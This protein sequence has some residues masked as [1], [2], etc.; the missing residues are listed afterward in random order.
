MLDV[1]KGSLQESD[2]VPA[3]V[4]ELSATLIKGT[5]TSPCDCTLVR[6]V[7][8]DGQYAGKGDVVFE[9]V[10]HDAQ[11]GIEAR[12]PYKKFTAVQPGTPVSFRVAG[13]DQWLPGHIVSSTLLDETGLSS[14]LRVHIQP[15]AP[16]TGTHTGR[17]AQVDVRRWF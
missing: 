2:L 8:A 17:V 15:D 1:L 4:T 5:L 16:L 7:V 12:F 13:E 3:K 14:D 6:Q 9:L 11:A 10:P